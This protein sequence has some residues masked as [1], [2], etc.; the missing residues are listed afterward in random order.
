MA[1]DPADDKLN[2]HC[3]G[4]RGTPTNN[5]GKPNTLEGWNQ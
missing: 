4:C 2:D 3:L 1:D 5:P